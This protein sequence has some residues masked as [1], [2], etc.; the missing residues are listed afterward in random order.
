MLHG[1]K[2]TDQLC[3]AG[4]SS[5]CAHE[6]K[7]E[8]EGTEYWYTYGIVHPQTPKI[9]H[10]G[11]EFFLP[12]GASKPWCSSRVN[13]GGGEERRE[14]SRESHRQGDGQGEAHVEVTAV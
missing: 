1:H 11:M 14:L 6:Y 5:R 3:V 10:C 4:S 7:Q 8:L 12:A 2:L 9:I 13:G